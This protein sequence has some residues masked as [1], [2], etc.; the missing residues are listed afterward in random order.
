MK[1]AFIVGVLAAAIAMLTPAAWA[2]DPIK[3]CN[4]DDRSGPA[5]DVGTEGHNGMQI[6]V[7]EINAAG[8]IGGR[9]IEV[10]SYDGKTDPQLS[11]SFAAR[12]AEDDKVLLI[13]GLGLTA[14]ATAVVPMS[15]EYK[16]PLMMFAVS[17][18]TVTDN[19]PWAFRTGIT[20]AQDSAAVVELIVAQGF[21]RVALVVTSW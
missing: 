11:A 2:A 17:A 10:V 1:L 20:N 6:A 7:A 14:P 16:V 9:R 19:G 5:A 4:I 3:I 15:A 8:G 18:D 13:T 12:C 21:K